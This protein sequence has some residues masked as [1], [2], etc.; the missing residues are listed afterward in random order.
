MFVEDKSPVFGI[1][2]PKVAALAGVE[3]VNPKMQATQDAA[4]LA[5]MSYRGQ[6]DYTADRYGL[7]AE[8][9]KVGDDFNPEVGFMRRFDFT[10]SSAGLRFSPRPTFTRAIRKF[11]YAASVNHIEDGNG[12]LQTRERWGEFAL[13]FPNTDRFSVTFLNTLESLPKP[14][15][16]RFH[17]FF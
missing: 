12:R 16:I 7:N 15:T 1:E 17:F 6:F 4:V 13:E 5:L 3:L 11:S 2:Q 8:R 14:F 10:K 9:L